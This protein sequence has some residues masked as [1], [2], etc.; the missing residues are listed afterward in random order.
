MYKVAVLFAL[1]AL[2]A[3]ALAAPESK[4]VF[5]ECELFRYVRDTQGSNMPKTWTC[6]AYYESRYNSA[7]KGG[8]NSNGSYDHG[9]WQIN[10]NYWCAGDNP[11]LSNDCNKPCTAFR[12]NDLDD[13]WVCVVMIHGRHGFS[14]WSTYGPYCTNAENE[15][16]G[17]GC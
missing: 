2:A 10:D 17:N 9:M 3:Q 11:G 12:D 1:V 16:W 4:K 13:D 7:A 8:P 5:T 14:A 6:I 15:S